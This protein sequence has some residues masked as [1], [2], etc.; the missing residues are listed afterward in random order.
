VNDTVSVTVANESSHID[1]IGIYL[2]ALGPAGCGPNSRVFNT[3][4]MLA[5]GDRITY[6]VPV[7]YTCSDPAAA[8]GA[9][10]TWT[11]VADHGADDAASCPPGSLQGVTCFNALANDDADP[12]DD[13]LSRNGPKVVAQ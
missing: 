13:R 2:D 12:A 8:N 6:R 4:T 9:S 11:A 1:N 10:Y 5:P 7:S 3:T